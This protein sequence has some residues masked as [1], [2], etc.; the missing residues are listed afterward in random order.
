MNSSIA[1]FIMYTGLFLVVGAALFVFAFFRPNARRV[2]DLEAAIETA[3]YNL[4]A[5]A[6]RDELHPQMEFE[7]QN[8]EYLLDSWE[9]WFRHMR[10][11]WHNYYA[12]FMPDFFDEW[13]LRQRID[14]IVSPHS[15]SVQIEVHHGQQSTALHYSESGA[16]GMSPGI[17]V[18]PVWVTFSTSY[19]GL[20]EV[21]RGFTN[22]GIDN[23]IIEYSLNRVGD[24]M[25]DV[26]MRLDVITEA[27]IV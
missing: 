8:Q 2:E 16:Y 21:L 3:N 17:W 20:I 15:G 25:W 13:D 22:E 12:H 26:H 10:D 23:R 5:A 19:N 4:A 6:S 27:P 24:D 7:V 14:R 11:T 18:T 1:R 9:N